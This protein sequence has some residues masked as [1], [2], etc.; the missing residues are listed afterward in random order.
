MLKIN[1]ELILEIN[2]VNETEKYKSKVADI[3][4]DSIYI[5]YPVSLSTNRTAFLPTGQK[6]YANFVDEQ[7]N[8]FL[9][10]TE[11]TGRVKRN[12]PMIVLHY[13]GDEKLL[14]VQRR[15]FVRIETAIDI[16]L[17]FPDSELKF[18]TVTFDISAGGC[19]AVLPRTAN[20]KNGEMGHIHLVMPMQTGEYSYISL[21]CKIV[22]IFDKSNLRLASLSFVNIDEIAQQ[23][24][25]RFCFDKQLEYR[26]KGLTDSYI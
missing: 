19:A 9:F 26:K 14:K 18:T 10:E 21:Q 7:T 8:A 23:Q 1:M 2:H 11:V 13:P 16:A 24:L 3:E 12:I 25:I 6:L 4:E 5:Q 22:R 20:L 17:D 15:E